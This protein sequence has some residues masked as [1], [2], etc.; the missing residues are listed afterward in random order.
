MENKDFIWN[1][2][3]VGTIIKEYSYIH[4]DLIIDWNFPAYDLEAIT[5]IMGTKEALALEKKYLLYS[6]I[7]KLDVSE[8]KDKLYRILN[9]MKS[10]II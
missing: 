1:L 8:L 7:E 3:Y 6:D 9:D 4:S 2:I 5:I 10:T